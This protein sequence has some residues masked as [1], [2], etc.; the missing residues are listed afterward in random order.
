M[1]WRATVVAASAAVVVALF[2]SG[3]A[4]AV[5]DSV[6][7][8]STPQTGYLAIPATAF[9]ALDDNYDYYFENRFALRQGTSNFAC[10]A[11]PVNLPQG[12]DMTVLTAWF[13]NV[14]GTASLKLVRQLHTGFL[15]DLAVRPLPAT[16]TPVNQQVSKA[17]T[18]A[19][20]IIDNQN[21]A[22]WVEYCVNNGLN[23]ILFTVRVTYTFTT[24][25]D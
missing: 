15:K 11:A 2:L 16:A 25:G 8:Y 6:F 7:R 10:Y 17:I 5:T 3:A 12:A 24:A 23:A 14:G 4:Y 21:N 9:R 22:Y 1:N 18:D 19:E 20:A 13:A